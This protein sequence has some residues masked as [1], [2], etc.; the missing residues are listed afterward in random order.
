MNRIYLDYAATTPMD[1]EVERAMK[2]YFSE[3]FGNPNSLHYFG[4]QARKT[5]DESREK[6]VKSI[7]ADFREVIFTGSAT[8]ANN[9]A[10]RGIA[11]RIM[12]NEVRI[13]N[14]EFK[15][16]IIHNS[17]SIIP[18][19]IVSAIEHESVLETARDLEKNGVEIIYLP[20]DKN[21]IVNLKKLKEALNENTILVSIMYA[22]NETG[23]IQPIAEISKIIKN[24]RE[25]LR[26]KNYELSDKK[27]IHQFTNPPIYPLF[28][29]DAVQA[30]QFLNCNV[31]DLG[32]DLMT[33][34][35]H[36]IYGPKGMGALYINSKH[37]ARNSKQI[38]NSK[39]KLKNK[40]QNISDFQ[41]VSPLITGGGQEFGLRSG[42][43][44][45]AGIVGFAKA[46]ELAD[47]NREK[48]YKRI[49]E[50]KKYFWHQLE[51]IFPATQINAG[52]IADL[53]GKSKELKFLPNILN[54]Y[55]PGHRAEE[56][57]IK[58]DL[59]GVAVSS[60]S[61]CAAFSSKPSHVLKALGYNEKKINS[62]LRFSFGKFTTKGD[63]DTTF[64]II[65]IVLKN[66]K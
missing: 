23:V 46:I 26:I 42:T 7:G 64:K 15:K 35:A 41:A 47:K 39:L 45:V 50:L 3:H 11:K 4:Q 9:L 17:S 44:N 6:I 33:L 2:P 14:K 61:A 13:K 21:G 43:E 48:E 51:K 38:Q 36:K 22:N 60:G 59:N 5:V 40:I 52:Q 30:F 49:S 19:I 58:L 37:E 10:I 1:K 18:R 62:I 29:T 55:F 27:S 65:K 28:H 66:N 16:T 56:L 12:N 54:V 53:R 25:E 63:L 8:E 34:S 20:V 57:L 32:V 31:N 24:F